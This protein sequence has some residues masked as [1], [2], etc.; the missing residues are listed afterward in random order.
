MIS[1]LSA[2]SVLC[3]AQHQ[4]AG[5]KQLGSGEGPRTRLDGPWKMNVSEASEVNEGRDALDTIA[6]LAAAQAD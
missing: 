5:S 2:T 1:S 3:L 4:Y 6:M